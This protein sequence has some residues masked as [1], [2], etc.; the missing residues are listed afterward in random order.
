RRAPRPT[1]H[2][3]LPRP[4]GT[5]QGQT[6]P[7]PGGTVERHTAFADRSATR[8]SLPAEPRFEAVE[9]TQHRP[10]VVADGS[11]GDAPSRDGRAASGAH[12]RTRVRG[13]ELSSRAVRRRPA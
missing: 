5:D 9:G 1:L 11:G 2:P 3:V 4:C 7:D 13:Y 10:A 8:H 6:P 12:V